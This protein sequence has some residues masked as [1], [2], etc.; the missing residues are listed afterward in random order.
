MVLSRFRF[1]EFERMR[2]T[3]TFN[4]SQANFPAFRW[5]ESQTH[6][7]THVH[8]DR[9]SLEYNQLLSLL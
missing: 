1:I 5:V 4:T 2:F 7:H 8:T 9:A 3:H 6:T